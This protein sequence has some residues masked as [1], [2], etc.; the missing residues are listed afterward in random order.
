MQKEA[1]TATAGASTTMTEVSIVKSISIN[2][3]GSII[4]THRPQPRSWPEHPLSEPPEPPKHH[5]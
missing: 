4:D 5:Q 2:I 3:E 1:S